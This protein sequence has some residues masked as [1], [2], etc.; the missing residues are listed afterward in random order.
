[1]PVEWPVAIDGFG[2]LGGN[3]RRENGCG[4][5]RGS[6]Q[7]HT[8]AAHEFDDE[9]IALLPP[10]CGRTHL[11]GENGYADIRVRVGDRRPYFVEI[12]YGYEPADIVAS[13]TRK[14]S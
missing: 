7:A 6:Q 14:Y 1:V 10:G 11:G 9:Y 5:E 3:R 2:R 13:V 12:D 4:N 8:F